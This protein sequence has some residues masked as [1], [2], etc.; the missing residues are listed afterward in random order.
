M[1]IRKNERERRSKQNKQTKKEAHYLFT[2][3]HKQ[4]CHTIKMRTCDGF[5]STYTRHSSE[6]FAIRFEETNA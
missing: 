1:P 3:S 2:I 4:R 6:R 5:Y